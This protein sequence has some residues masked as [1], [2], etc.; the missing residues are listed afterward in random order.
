MVASQMGVH[1]ST[2]HSPQHPF[3]RT[4]GKKKDTFFGWIQSSTCCMN[5]SKLM[6]SKN[7][8]FTYIIWVENLKNPDGKA[9]GSY[10]VE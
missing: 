6:S 10:G 4:L 9:N 8:N 2:G 5:N 7:C 1:P 3:V